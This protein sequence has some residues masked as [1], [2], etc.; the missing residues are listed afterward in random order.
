MCSKTK[1]VR[2]SRWLLL[3]L[4][5]AVVLVG[6]ATLD[7]LRWQEPEVRVLSSQLVRL[8]PTEAFLDTRFEVRNPN[9]FSIVLGALDYTLEVNTAQVLQGEQSQGQ[10]LSAGG[11]QEINLPVRLE[12]AELASLVTGF[13][14][15]DAVDYR[16]AGG[17]S[18]D[19]PVAGNVRVPAEAAGSVP[20]PR[21]PQVQVEN[22]T[23]SNLSLSGADLLLS[24]RV[25]NP[26]AFELLLDRFSYEFALDNN[27]VAGGDGRQRMRLEEGGDGLLELPL[28]VSFGA[29]GRSLYNAIVG[30]ESIEYGLSFESELQ[31]GLP[32]METFPFSA[33][34]DGQIRLR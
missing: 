14:Q 11:T 16:I 27:R 31:P 4:I 7:D 15:R 1:K 17:M 6:C 10:R 13:A 23:T 29:A 21:M 32:Q 20:I 26:N 8:T 12:F 19:I 5:S 30:G 24:L 2:A 9:V 28:T 33:V 3:T 18:F 34:Q 22:L 25:S